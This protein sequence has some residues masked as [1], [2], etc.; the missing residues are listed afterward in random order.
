MFGS[1]AALLLASI[2]DAAVE[3]SLF[4]AAKIIILIVSLY[5]AWDRIRKTRPYW[6]DVGTSDWTSLSTSEY[7]FRLP[8]SMHGRG[9]TPHPRAM[10]L[11]PA[12]YTSVG[13]DELIQPDGTVIFRVSQPLALRLEVRK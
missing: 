11:G 10:E 13:L 8:R 1:I 5:L 9:K 4:K 6:K 12:G 2:V 3:S 7:E